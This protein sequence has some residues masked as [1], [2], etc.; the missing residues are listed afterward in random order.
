MTITHERLVVP[1]LRRAF[2]AVGE[3]EASIEGERRE[4]EKPSG[5]PG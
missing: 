4:S 5:P 3:V 1:L 2:P